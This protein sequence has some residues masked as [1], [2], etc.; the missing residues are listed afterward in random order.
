[1]VIPTTSSPWGVA[2]AVGFRTDP[3]RAYLGLPRSEPR[4]DGCSPMS[5]QDTCARGAGSGDDVL[6]VT[7]RPLAVHLSRSATACTPGSLPARTRHSRQLCP[8]L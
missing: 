1:M 2:R 5:R 6:E 4:P 8:N 7:A 3:F